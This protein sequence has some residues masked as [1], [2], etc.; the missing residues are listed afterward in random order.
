MELKLVRKTFGN[1]F[2]KGK[3]FINSGFECYVLEDKDRK[4]EV[5]GV[6]VQDST[7]IPRGTYKVV[8]NHS[9]HFG[10][11]MPQILNVPQFEGVRIHS[12]NSSKDT[13]GCLIVGSTNTTDSSDWISASRDA[14][15]DLYPKI[16]K[17]FE[18]G[19]EITIEIV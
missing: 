3:L 9:Q 18:L 19:E 5:G 13:Q 1:T 12:G 14:V 7:C 8:W 16:Q 11:D 2:T 4:L 6:K 17:A 10:K 15:A